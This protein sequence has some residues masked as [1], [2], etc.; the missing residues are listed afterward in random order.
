MKTIGKLPI[1]FYNFKS[2]YQK[3]ATDLTMGPEILLV[4]QAHI[5]SI[6]AVW[7]NLGANNVSISDVL[8]LPPPA[9]PKKKWKELEVLIY[10]P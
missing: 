1:V 4:P 6:A 5:R 10:G 9:F 8:G 3:S 2:P 7:F